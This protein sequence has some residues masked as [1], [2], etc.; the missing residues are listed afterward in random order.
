MEQSLDFRTL[1][2]WLSIGKVKQNSIAD[3]NTVHAGKPDWETLTKLK[4]EM[5]T[6]YHKTKGGIDIV[7]ELFSKYDVTLNNKHWPIFVLCNFIHV[8]YE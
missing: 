2:P 3:V 6:F 4:P 8:W 7:D 1:L 5:V